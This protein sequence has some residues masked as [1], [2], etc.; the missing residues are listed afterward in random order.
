MSKKP[1]MNLS[2]ATE[3]AMSSKLQNLALEAETDV[4]MGGTFKCGGLVVSGTGVTGQG[5]TISLTSD[6]LQPVDEASLGRGSSGSVRRCILRRTGQQVAMKQIKVTNEHH[7]TEIQKELEALYKGVSSPC[8][9][10]IDFYGA[11]AQEGSVHIAM[12]LMEG[13]LADFTQPVPEPILAKM[14]SMILGGLDFLHRVRKL[15]HRDLKPSN[16]LYNQNGQVKIT[17]FGVS[18]QLENTGAIAVS[19]VG[20]VTYMSPERL[21]GDNYSFPG[22]IWSLGILAAELALGRHPYQ[23]VLAHIGQHGTEA[24]F[25]ALL[26]H[27]TKTDTSTSVDLPE[28]LSPGFRD[29]VF[30]CL[31]KDPHQRPSAQ[32]LLSHPWIAQHASAAA[33][34]DLSDVK[35]WIQSNRPRR[36][37]SIVADTTQISNTLA[38]LVDKF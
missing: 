16:L 20:T 24:K 8:P 23:Q 28:L 33:L 6:D 26:Q 36:A 21:K 9:F 31:Q 1:S 29:F 15:V 10:L 38:A 14:M 27:L 3:D 18:S 12:E 35:A 13:S 25:W 19:F 5:N 32:M 34:S 37:E 2:I 7:M 22:D 30:H 17:D 11:Y 4:S